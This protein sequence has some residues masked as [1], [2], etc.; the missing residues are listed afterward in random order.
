M[1]G[2]LAHYTLRQL[3]NDKEVEQS[4]E[5][6]LASASMSIIVPIHDAPKVSRRCL[7]SLEKYAPN[8]EIVLVDDASRLEETNTLL[9]DFL[10]RNNWK[11]LRHREPLGHSAACGA[12][13]SMATRPYLCLLN[14]DT[15]VTPWCWRL[16]K[17][18]FEENANM[19][20]AGPST[21]HSHNQQALPLV[22]ASRYCLND[23]QICEFAG[24]LFAKSSQPVLTDLCDVTGF[25]F[26]I[27]RSVW[28]QLGGFDRELPDYGNETELCRRVL[29]LG[30]RVVWI[31]NS[32]IHHFGN[33]SYGKE[34]GSESIRERKK[35]AEDYIKHKHCS[36]DP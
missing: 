36:W 19:G 17:L 24:R 9:K 4:A 11:L 15:V 27:R 29:N 6:A 2:L 18:A 8:S 35:S 31:R 30:Y 20:V 28:D 23:R 13:A 3:S 12:G 16:I 14:S 5:D 26:F 21:S 33:A 32:Y 34:I 22:R 10:S 7:M 25:A 1:D